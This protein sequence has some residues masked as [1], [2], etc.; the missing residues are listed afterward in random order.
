MINIIM[1]SDLEDNLNQIE[2]GEDPEEYGDLDSGDES[3]EDDIVD[4]DDL[5]DIAEDE[6]NGITNEELEDGDT[7]DPNS[8]EAISERHFAEKFLESLGGSEKV[9][10]GDVMG[11]DMDKLRDHSVNGWS[12]PV[13]PDVYEYLTTPYEV[14][15]EDNSY[16]ELR[17]EPHGPTPEAMKCGDSSLAL[18]FFFMSVALWQHIAVCCNNYKHEQLQARVEDYIKR[19]IKIQRRHPED[20]TSTRTPRDVRMSLMAVRLFFRM[21]Y[22][23]S[24]ARPIQPN[25]E[26]ISNHWKVSDE[27]DFAKGVFGNY[28]PRDR[29][30]EISRNLH[31]S[32]NLDPRAKTDRTWKIREVV[33]VLQHTFRRGYIPPEELT[34]DEAMLPSRSFFNTARM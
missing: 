16:L 5:N 34:F 21:N 8:V 23:F 14:V 30:L 11:Q 25:R 33:H 4:E 17:R 27:G 19:R 6:G 22:V 12:D 2:E 26:K 1:S 29:F 7:E 18:I 28:M 10:V 20:T 24:L 31:F 15:S 9:L 3:V 32:S 13:Y